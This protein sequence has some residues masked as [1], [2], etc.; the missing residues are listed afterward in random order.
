MAV[1]EARAR[2]L[3][4]IIVARTECARFD[5]GKSLRAGLG[6]G[7]NVHRTDHPPSPTD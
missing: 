2:Q 3:I 6:A 5:P 4:A 1:G 7:W